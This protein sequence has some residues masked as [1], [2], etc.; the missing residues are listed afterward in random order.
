MSKIIISVYILTTSLALI[1]LKLGA[2]AGP[3]VN[4]LDNKLHLNITPYTIIGILLYGLSF[5]IYIY[6]ISKYDLGYIIPLTTAFVYIIIFTASFF[7]FKE[8]FTALK[9]TG[10]LLIISGLVFLNLKK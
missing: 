7:I 3:L 2:K 4:Y 9:I 8:V 1:V 6:L 10:I 5:L